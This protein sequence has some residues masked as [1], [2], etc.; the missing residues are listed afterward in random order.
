MS[1]DR[2]LTRMWEEQPSFIKS[3]ETGLRKSEKKFGG[4]IRLLLTVPESIKYF[5]QP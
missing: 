5:H 1:V 3:L 4:V 2:G